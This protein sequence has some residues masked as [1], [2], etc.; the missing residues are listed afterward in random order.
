MDVFRQQL[1]AV[2]D[3]FHIDAV[4]IGMLHSPEVGGVDASF[5]NI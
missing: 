4:K 2:M 5:A 3:D 1:Q